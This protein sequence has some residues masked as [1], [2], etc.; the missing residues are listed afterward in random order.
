MHTAQTATTRV[1]DRVIDRAKIG[2]TAHVCMHC[3][4]SCVLVEALRVPAGQFR[5]EDCVMIFYIINATWCY[6]L[7]LKYLL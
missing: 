4:L 7:N 1:G 6:F 2:Q 5:V 3:L